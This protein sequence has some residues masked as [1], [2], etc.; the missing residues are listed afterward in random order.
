MLCLAP[1]DGRFLAR[2]QKGY[3]EGWEATS[4]PALK[5][6]I[7]VKAWQIPLLTIL[8]LYNMV[9][10]NWQFVLKMAIGWS[11]VRH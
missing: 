7:K 3:D 9:K 2:A 8:C 1:A 11:T 5:Q 6:K 4:I 10:G